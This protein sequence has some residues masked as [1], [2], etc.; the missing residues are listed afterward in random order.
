MFDVS[1]D[2]RRFLMVRRVGM[3][4]GGPAPA[5]ILVE[6]WF[7]ELRAKLGPTPRA[8]RPR[9][10]LIRRAAHWSPEPFLTHLTRC[11]HKDLEPGEP[12]LIDEEAWSAARRSFAPHIGAS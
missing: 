9:I 10:L 7:E 8:D 5:L 3:E 12:C 4:E 1:P 11:N 2:D 6:H